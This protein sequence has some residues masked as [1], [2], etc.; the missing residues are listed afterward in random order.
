M[1]CIECGELSATE[2]CA[3]CANENAI[4]AA[5]RDS[6]EV[7][8]MWPAVES[9]IRRRSTI[10]LAAAASIALLL[11]ASAVFLIRRPVTATPAT[12]VA[13][14]YR[15]A[16]AN[17]RSDAAPPRLNTAIDAAERGAARA[18]NDPVEVTRLVAA[19][20]AKLQFL[21]ATAND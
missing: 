11:I 7:P 6:I 17:L 20:D 18:P 10:S 21:R 8:P 3:A 4:F 5:Y 1:N 16:I 2:T 19:Y 14:H 12:D 9:R 15:A 13:T